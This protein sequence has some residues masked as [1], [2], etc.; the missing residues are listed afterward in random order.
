MKFKLDENVPFSLKKVIESA[1]DHRVDSVFHEKKTGIDDHS[2][3]KLCLSE[4]RVLLTLDTDF[5]NPIMHPKGSFY[6]ILILRPSSQGKT[7]VI[8][9][10]TDFLARFNLEAV[11]HK[12]LLIEPDTIT[13]R[14]DCL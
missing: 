14:W 10:F 1:G 9:L 13:I 4:E 7:A 2:L 8:D 3:L 11:P 5:N 12:V 6:G